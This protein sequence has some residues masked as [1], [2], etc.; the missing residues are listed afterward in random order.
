MHKGEL[1]TISREIIFIGYSVVVLFF[2]FLDPPGP[3]D[4][5]RISI[6]KNGQLC[7]R[8]NSD[9][10]QLSG[11]MWNFL[12]DIYGGGPELIIKQVSQQT[13]AVQAKT[14]AEQAQNARANK[15][16]NAQAPAMAETIPENQKVAQSQTASEQTDDKID[17][18]AT[19]NEQVAEPMNSD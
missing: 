3:I 14:L 8:Q 7:V 18:N 19:V 17:R 10:G 12:Y 15:S 4:N 13:L 16:E 6:T 11:D 5:K 9:H 2:I 1:S